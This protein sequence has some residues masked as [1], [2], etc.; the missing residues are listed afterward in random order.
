MSLQIDGNT[1]VRELVGRFPQTRAV[2]ERYG[3]DYCCGGGKCL[4]EAVHEN[5]P[6]LP[7]LIR[8]IEAALTA[9]S[10]GT[11]TVE[12]DWYAA[13]LHELIDH[14]V[15]VHHVYMKEALPRLGGLMPG[16][17]QSQIPELN[18]RREST[19]LGAHW[20][21]SAVARRGSPPGWM[22]RRTA[23]AALVREANASASPGRLV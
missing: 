11:A 19:E 16:E 17:M 15:K 2:F 7:D 9:T 6:A 13:P 21:R 3:I 8:D 12:K 18:P 4:A 14:I 5:Q 20:I 22:R 1:T 23:R 10:T